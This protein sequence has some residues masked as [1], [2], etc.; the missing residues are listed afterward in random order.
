[1][2]LSSDTMKRALSPGEGT[3]EFRTMQ[4][5]GK[6]GSVLAYVGM[7]GAALP[8]LLEFTSMAPPALTNSKWGGTVIAVLGGL[9]ALIGLLKKTMTE[10]AYIQGRSLVKAAAVRNIVPADVTPATPVV[11]DNTGT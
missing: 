9:I 7:I 6:F 8:Q 2:D 11:N 4:A 5:S 1:M 3:S 10:V